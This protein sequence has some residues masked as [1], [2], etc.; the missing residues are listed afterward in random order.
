MASA[1]VFAFSPS[2]T[3]VISTRVPM[4]R[5]LALCSDC[6]WSLTQD[7]ISKADNPN[8]RKYLIWICRGLPIVMLALNLGPASHFPRHT[9][10]DPEVGHGLTAGDF[11]WFPKYALRNSKMALYPLI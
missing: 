2:P 4:R 9:T 3:T 8:V 7:I 6:F 1:A 10:V 11:D 5:R